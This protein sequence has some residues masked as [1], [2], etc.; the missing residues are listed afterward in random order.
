MSLFVWKNYKKL[1]YKVSFICKILQRKLLWGFL[2]EFH[3]FLLFNS[4]I[5]KWRIQNIKNKKA[6]IL[7]YTSPQWRLKQ[8]NNTLDIWQSSPRPTKLNFI[9]F[10]QTV[11][12]THEQWFIFRTM[13]DEVYTNACNYWRVDPCETSFLTRRLF[14][15]L[16]S[17]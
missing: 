3:E 9:I 17:L 4:F 16:C 5:K 10:E 15:F 7:L 13:F 6:I 11:P 2:L 8:K 1:P 14:W 12:L